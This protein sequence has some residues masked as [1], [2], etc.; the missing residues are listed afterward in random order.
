MSDVSQSRRQEVSRVV[1]ELRVHGVS[2]SEA[3]QVL[4]R[5]YV[6]QVAGDR[7]GGFYRP[8]PGYPDSK[9]PGGVVLEA[10]RWSDLPSGTASRTL[11]LVFMLP[12]MLS[13][14]A[15]WMRP[16]G[17][18]SGAGVKVLCR[19][20]ALNLT[21]LYVLSATGVALDLIAWKCMASAQCLAGRT[22]LSW[23]GYRPVGL[24]L[25]VLTLLPV[26]AVALVWLLGAR[27]GRSYDA[28]RAPGGGPRGDRLN[29]VGQWD[30]MPMV[31]RLRAIHIAAAFAVLALTLLAASG[32]ADPSPVT[33][34]LAA[35]AVLVLA[36]CAALLCAPT[37]LERPRTARTPDGLTS[38]LRATACGLIVVAVAVVA[39]NRTRWPPSDGLPGYGRIV[40]WVLLTQMGLLVALGALA[41]WRRAGRDPRPALLRGLGAPVIAAVAVGLA[42]ALSAELIYRTAY[43]LN[44]RAITGRP[45]DLAAPP[46][47]YKWAIFTFFF[48]TVAAVL[49]GA[50]M[51]LLSRRG[52]LRAAAA[53]VAADFPAAPPAAAARMERVETTIARARFTE[54]LG[55]LAIAYACLTALGLAASVLGLFGLQ[56]SPLAERFLGVP[57]DFVNFAITIGSYLIAGVVVALLVG[58]LFAYRTAEFRRYVGVL[59]DLGTFWPRAAH[60]FAPPCYAERAVPELAKRICYLADR[61]AGVLL[62]G[63]SHGS[64]LLAATV[65][66][67]PPQVCRR[68]A[69]LTYGS[70]LDR[71]YARLFPAYLGRDVLHEVGDRIGW[72]WRNLWRDTDP[73]GGWMFAA[74][75][76]GDPPAGDASAAV[77]RRLRDPQDVVAPPGDS[78]P[79]PIK[80]H[81]P[82]ESDE[83][84][85]D[86]AR[87]LVDRLRDPGRG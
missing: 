31:G 25:A 43:F 19:L 39:L 80:G 32:A 7:S 12:F 54:R 44:R 10:Y 29:A 11:S 71:L 75:R 16:A 74:H 13:N 35:L 62:T 76:P 65:L 59:W 24:R 61:H 42:G 64:V 52:R 22:W 70:P 28:F 51:T 60:P 8:R 85:T 55:P 38:A 87:E 53:I 67:L 2:G 3:G 78:V 82:C 9:G 36:A 63:H 79:P 40:G 68:V 50:G 77:D 21:L 18:G 66:Q 41:L 6:Y 48:T 37:L 86:A 56:P 30:A 49:V 83:H 58:G 69:L 57:S 72:R 45:D 20:V 5:P 17:R 47:G 73:I 27:P 34:A 1:V 23:L 14:V 15:I 33:T 84:F 46:L 4:D 26:S 81:W